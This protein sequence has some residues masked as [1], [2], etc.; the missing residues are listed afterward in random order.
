MAT[1]SLSATS[2]Q[3]YA[4]AAGVLLLFSMIGGGLGEFYI[5]NR[6]IVNGDAAATAHNIVTSS[7]LY[8]FGFAAYLVEAI[9]DITLAL[10]FYVLLRPVNKYVALLAAFFGLVSTAV[11]AGGELFYYAPTHILGGAGYLNTFSTEQLNTLSQLSLKLYG[12][13]AGIFMALYGIATSIRGYLMYRSEYLPK[14]LGA[15]VVIAGIGFILKNF[16]LVLAPAFPSDLFLLPMPLV[17]L[18]MMVWFLVKGVDVSKW[19][20]KAAV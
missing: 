19:E 16:M 3:T 4:R 12:L 1:T 18:S 9:C 5:P 13:C 20:A 8:R 6:M 10:V 7:A 2:A 15:L 17:V 11:F 14:W